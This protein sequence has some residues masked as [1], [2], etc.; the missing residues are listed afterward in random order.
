M[1]TALMNFLVQTLIWKFPNTK[2]KK[3]IIN[4]E[5][6]LNFFIEFELIKN[7]WNSNEKWV[8]KNRI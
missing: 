1:N 8:Y 3:N 5:K 2:N 7:E 6:I 4:D